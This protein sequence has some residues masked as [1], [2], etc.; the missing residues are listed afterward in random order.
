MALFGQ[1]YLQMGNWN[2]KQ[3]VPEDWIKVSTK[4]YSVI[5]EEYSIGYGMLWY[6]LMKTELRK[7]KSFFHT[8]AGIHMLGIYPDSKLVLVHRVDTEKVYSFNSND[9]QALMLI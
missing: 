2:G 3:I 1:L 9:F 6:V 7:S 4:A 8:G 5:I